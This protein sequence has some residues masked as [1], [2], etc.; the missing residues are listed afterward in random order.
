MLPTY[1]QNLFCE[2]LKHYKKNFQWVSSYGVDTESQ[3]K[4]QGEIISKVRKLE[5]SFLY[6]SYCHDMFYI[7]V[8]YREN[9]LTGSQ[10]T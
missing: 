7:T 6:A 9:I 4:P 5:L 10:I 8:K 1:C 2:I 3:L